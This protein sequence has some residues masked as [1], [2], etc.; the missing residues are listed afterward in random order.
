MKMG[1]YILILLV[2]SACQTL[3]KEPVRINRQLETPADLNAYEGVYSDSTI[4]RF[5]TI[6]TA[7]IGKYYWVREGFNKDITLREYTEPENDAQSNVVPL[8]KLM[9]KKY[10]QFYNL[11]P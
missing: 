9:T 11:Y 3:R 2:F 1:R 4:V 10:Y 7:K 8:S 5:L 6:D